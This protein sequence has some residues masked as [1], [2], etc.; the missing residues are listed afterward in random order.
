MAK[1][2][3]Y[4]DT[5]VTTWLRSYRSIEADS[6]K[7]AMEIAKGIFKDDT[8]QGEFELETLDDTQ[9]SISVED[10]SGFATVELLWPGTTPA[11]KSHD[12]GGLYLT[13]GHSLI[14]DN[15]PVEV[16]RNEKIDN[17]LKENT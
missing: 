12:T 3:F 1:Y 16:V 4:I 10:N 13:G 6:E 7:E 2:S 11:E 14:M 8:G 17:I 15:R 5:K 9:E